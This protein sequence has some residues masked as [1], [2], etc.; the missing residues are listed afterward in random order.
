MSF[1][2]LNLICEHTRKYEPPLKFYFTSDILEMEEHQD[3]AAE[4]LGNSFTNS[5]PKD[6]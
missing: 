3:N 6:E 4:P 1:C 5:L 2:S